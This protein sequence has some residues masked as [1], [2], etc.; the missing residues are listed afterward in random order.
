MREE[1]SCLLVCLPLTLLI[2]PY[3]WDYAMQT[4]HELNALSV[5]V[6]TNRCENIISLSE[7]LLRV[8]ANLTMKPCDNR[9]SVCTKICVHTW[10]LPW[11][12][13]L[14]F[15]SLWCWRAIE[16]SHLPPTSVTMHFHNPSPLQSHFLPLHLPLCSLL[17]PLPSVRFRH[18]PHLSAFSVPLLPNWLYKPA[19]LAVSCHAWVSPNVF[20]D[21]YVCVWA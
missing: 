9:M 10:V 13:Q 8:W 12:S 4:E 19:W 20:V 1:Q 3:L 15:G 21:P 14:K 5:V 2:F 18:P 7:S 17:T 16:S 11:Q 6:R